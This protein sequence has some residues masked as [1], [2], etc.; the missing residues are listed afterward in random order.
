MSP[1]FLGKRRPD[2]EGADGSM[3]FVSSQRRYRPPRVRA[4]ERQA[5]HNAL[6]EEHG[7]T[8]GGRRQRRAEVQVRIGDTDDIAERGLSRPRPPAGTPAPATEPPSRRAKSWSA[9]PVSFYIAPRSPSTTTILSDT[10]S[11]AE[12]GSGWPPAKRS[13]AAA[14]S[15]IG[16]S[17]DQ[18]RPDTAPTEPSGYNSTAPPLATPRAGQPGE[19]VHRLSQ[20]LNRSS[21]R[22]MRHDQIRQAGQQAPASSSTSPEDSQ[23]DRQPTPNICA[24][25]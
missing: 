16:S 1:A 13:R 10:P 17:S 8:V 5:A 4:V 15:D 24:P 9:S 18:Q 19:G 2:T 20:T 3:T 22:P 12:Q 25:R 21:T 7:R 14:Q 23:L 11:S 6:R